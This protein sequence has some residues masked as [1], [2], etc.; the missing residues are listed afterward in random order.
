M[1]HIFTIA[2]VLVLALSGVSQAADKTFKPDDEGYIRNWLMLDSP[3][4]LD[5]KASEHS[6]D[7]QKDF[8]DKEYIPNQFKATPA[9]GEKVKAG[10]ADKTWKALQSDDGVYKFESVD[11]ALYLAIAY[12]TAE[13]DMADVT[14]SIG[15]DDSSLWRVN[16]AEVVRVYSGRGVEKDQDKS[17]PFALKK[18]V[19]VVYAAVINGGG[20]TG[21]SARFLDKSDK[22]VNN[23]VISMAPGAGA[24]APAA[25]PAKKP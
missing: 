11:N 16:G 7:N 8:F 21:L 5:E 25:D 2:A 22:P 9:E 3:I 14:L 17:K 1:K 4:S 23:L 15:S 6:E 13:A 19:N 18:G 10:T 24:A 12:V 20:E